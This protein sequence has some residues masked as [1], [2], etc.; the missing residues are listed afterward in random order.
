MTQL[1]QIKARA[2]SDANR[3]GK[4]LAILNLNPYAPLY[5]IRGWDDRYE[6]IGHRDFV[7]KIEPQQG[8]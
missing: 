5:V 7:A 2:Q 4:P 8:V 6:T 3:E 1:E